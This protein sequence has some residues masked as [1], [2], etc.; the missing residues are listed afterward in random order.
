MFL[1]KK[2]FFPRITLLLLAVMIFPA[3]YSQ[4]K[5]WVE[6]EHFDDHGG[7][8][9]DWQFIDQMGSSY[10]MAAGYGEKVK[11]AVTEIKTTAPGKYRLW[12]RSNDWF[13][14]KHPGRFELEINGRKVKKNFGESGESGWRW[15]DAGVVSLAKTNT[16]R[17]KD[18]TGY[19]GRCDALVFS[20]DQDWRP[21]GDV[22]ELAALRIKFGAVSPEVTPKGNYDVVVVGGGVAG[23]LAAVAAAREGART[24]L[25][26][27]RDQLGGNASLENLVPPVGFRQT[28]LNAEER[29]YDPRETGL[30]EE[31]APYG[32]QTYFESG[33]L[34]PDRLLKLVEAEPL[35]D[36]YL[37]THAT[38]V[39]MAADNRIAG[40]ECVQVP[41]GKR[42]S[43]TGKLF[44]DCTGNGIVGLKSGAEYLYGR[45]ARAEYNETKAPDV[46]DKTTL[47]SSLKYWFTEQPEQAP[48]SSPDWAYQFHSCSDFT[49]GRHPKIGPI[50]NQWLIELGGTDKTYQNAEAVR[51]DLFRLIYGIWDHLKNHCP[52]AKGKSEKMKLAWVGHIVGLR[53][54]YRLLGDYVMSEKDVTEQPLLNDRISYGGWGLDDHPSLGFFDKERL[55]NHTHGGVYHSVPYRSLYSRNIENLMMAGRNISVTHVALTATRVMYATG[56]IGQAAG[57]AAG[58]CIRLGETPRGIYQKH[59]HTLQQKL[60]KEGA[61]LIE[62]P[63]EDPGDL[64]LSAVADASD[65]KETA[66]EVINGFSRAR[67]PSMFP[68]ARASMNAWV[69]DTGKEAPHWLS[70]GWDAPRTFN[71]VHVVFQNRG[72]LAY[73]SF[74]LEKLDDRQGWVLLKKVENPGL[75]RR[76]V[77]PVEETVSKGIRVVLEEHKP[78]GIA[79]IRVYRETAETLEMIERAKRLESSFKETIPLPW[80]KN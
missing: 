68:S 66:S 23:C 61:F 40:V 10:L 47:P 80:E 72:A 57:T 32:G 35:L 44:M 64:A 41:S 25:I 67:F 33:K 6:A 77:I 59:L 65:G 2:K 76:L 53:E 48:F 1:R 11:D 8:V 28:L 75:K 60:L 45:E 71:A 30:I 24:V 31:I 49:H 7:W 22:K 13:P 69:P 16:V 46:A 56:V 20:A 58:M 43:F 70:L 21:P 5:I 27:N 79:E 54:S 39:T 51:D 19:Y 14:E 9:N 18:L 12:V 42:I 50:D 62:M 15:E 17:M 4:E 55:N 34:W 38:E 26:Q 36:L 37:N 63:N 3:A 29:K 52:E 74:R 78:Y 73:G